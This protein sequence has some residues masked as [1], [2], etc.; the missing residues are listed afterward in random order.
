MEFVADAGRHFEAISDS[1][2]RI[3]A[4]GSGWIADYPAESGFIRV[5]LTCGAFV[6]G[7]VD[8]LNYAGFCDPR[9]DAQVARAVELQ[10]VDPHAAGELWATIDRRIVDQAPWVPLYNTRSIDFVSERVGNYQDHL[11]WGVLVDQLWVR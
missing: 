5:N 2:R 4:G 6:P 8:N 1:R 7:S 11:Q 10:G 9:M 3:Q